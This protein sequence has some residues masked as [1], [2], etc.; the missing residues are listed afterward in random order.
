[1]PE[2]NTSTSVGGALLSPGTSLF[3]IASFAPTREFLSRGGK[4]RLRWL[5][6][7]V[8]EEGREGGRFGEGG[9]SQ[10]F[11]AFCSIVVPWSTVRWTVDKLTEA[12][13]PFRSGGGGGGGWGVEG[14]REVRRPGVERVL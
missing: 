13:F 10:V 3:P 8:G 1:M 4:G 2:V 6:E 12:V 7:G 5:T 14:G 9:T 11:N